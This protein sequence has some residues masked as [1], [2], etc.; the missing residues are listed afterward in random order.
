MNDFP[1]SSA[2]PN[3]L[4]VDTGASHVLFQQKH[5]GLLRDVEI[6]HPDRPPFAI[7]RAANGQALR[8]IGRGILRVKKSPTEWS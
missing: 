5:I 8:S 3:D 2:Q 7:L 1:A 6:S 4:I